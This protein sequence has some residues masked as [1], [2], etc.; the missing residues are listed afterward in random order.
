MAFVG[1]YSYFNFRKE[2]KWMFWKFEIQKD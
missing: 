2:R 1:A